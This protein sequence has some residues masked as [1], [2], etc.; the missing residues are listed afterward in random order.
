MKRVAL[1]IP[2]AGP[3]ISLGVGK[4]LS[5]LL[6]L[7]LPIYLVDVVYDEV[8]RDKKKPGAVEIRNFVTTHPAIVHVVET[9]VGRLIAERR[10][11]QPNYRFSHAGETA[12][13]NFFARIDEIMIRASR[14]SSSLRTPR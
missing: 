13:A 10:A 3:L 14:S 6:K 12:I 1:V 7:D 2:D 9:E 5:L 11:T 4:S 8:T